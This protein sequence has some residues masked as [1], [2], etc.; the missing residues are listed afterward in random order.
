[1]TNV[2]KLLF[3]VVFKKSMKKVIQKKF[4]TTKKKDGLDDGKK[5]S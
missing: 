2:L 5:S 1:M 4:I 3:S